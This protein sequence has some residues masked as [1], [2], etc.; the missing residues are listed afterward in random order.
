MID[1]IRN[2]IKSITRNN[3][4]H[5]I[6]G[7]RIDYIISYLIIIKYFIEQGKYTLDDILK[8]KDL[9]EINHDIKRINY[10]YQEKS[11]PF[12]LVLLAYQDVSAKE[13]LLAFLRSYG[14]KYID[15]ELEK[16]VFSGVSS[17]DYSYYNEIGFTTYLI[18]NQYSDDYYNDFKIYDEILG[19]HNHYFKENQIDY[20]LYTTL[21]VIDHTPKYHFIKDD[22]GYYYILKAFQ[23]FQYVIL[24]TSYYKI[25]NFKA[26]RTLLRYLKL[27]IIQ[28]KKAYLYF[29]KDYIGTIS[30]IHYDSHRIKSIDQMKRIIKNNRKIKDVLVKTT[31]DEIRNNNMRIGFQLYQLE[32]KDDIQ[33]ISQIVDQ[34]TE[35]LKRLNYINFTVEQEMNNLLIK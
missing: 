9:I 27:V 24:D 16:T 26:G 10:Y 2:E 17:N 28:D 7:K 34:N 20:T 19:I 15:C 32:K 30:I 29:Q 5:I 25:S 6:V 33:D 22:N 1:K 35:F 18:P 4:D 23:T 8:R 11:T 31:A 12:H 13:L 21:Y 14:E 3:R